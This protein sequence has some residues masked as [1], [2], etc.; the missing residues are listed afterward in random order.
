MIVGVRVNKRIS[1]SGSKVDPARR[2]VLRAD[3]KLV[4][5]DRVET[6]LILP[7][8]PALRVHRLSWFQDK[9]KRYD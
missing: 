6:S 2:K 7:D 3:G 1:R 4:D 8:L 9:I 5:S